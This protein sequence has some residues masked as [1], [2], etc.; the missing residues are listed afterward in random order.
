[1]DIQDSEGGIARLDG[2]YLSKV[3]VQVDHVVFFVGVLHVS[4]R[5]TRQNHI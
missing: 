4:V 1:M 3:D 5:G 2:I